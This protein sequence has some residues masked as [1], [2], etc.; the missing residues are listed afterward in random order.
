MVVSLRS[1]AMLVIP[2]EATDL[3]QRAVSHKQ[4]LS[5]ASPNVRS[6]AVCAAHDDHWKTSRL[7]FHV[8]V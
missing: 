5:N 7:A 2:S 4:N 8:Y 1:I 6:F 3:P